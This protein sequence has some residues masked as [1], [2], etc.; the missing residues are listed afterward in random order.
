M[1]PLFQITT[2]ATTSVVNFMLLLFKT[3]RKTVHRVVSPFHV[4]GVFNCS[5]PQLRR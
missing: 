3:S 2:M 4:V 5:R 1:N